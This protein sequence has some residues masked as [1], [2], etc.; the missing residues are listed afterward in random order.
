MKKRSVLA[1]IMAA[2]MALSSMAVFA[3][4]YEAEYANEDAVTIT[5]WFR[6]YDE[7]KG[8]FMM[9]SECDEHIIVVT[10]ETKI[11][12]E[13]ALRLDWEVDYGYETTDNAWELLYGEQ[14]MGELLNGR[15]LVVVLEN[16]YSQYP[17]SITIL[18]LGISFGPADIDGYEFEAEGEYMGIVALP[19]AIDEEFIGFE[20]IG[21]E[22]ENISLDLIGMVNGEL[23]VEGELLE[24]APAAFWC[25]DSL[26]VMVP[27]R[28]AA[29]ALGFNVTWNHYTSSVQLGVAIHIWIDSAEVHYGRMAPLAMST[30]ARLVDVFT[31][32][33][34][35]FFTNI[36]GLDAYVFEGQ[37]VIATES[38]MQ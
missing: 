31:F 30:E 18:F 34:L 23:V 27:L 25:V 22:I 4:E 35:D 8:R 24:D 29:E 17:I 5:S 6:L 36:L 12:F 38:D 37:V 11:V 3:A 28:A 10:P 15:Q 20:P 14:T 32:V 2:V 33:P 9:I 7:G 19:I 16:E 21:I 13:H 26:T 1:I